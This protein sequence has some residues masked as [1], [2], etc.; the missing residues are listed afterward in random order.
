MPIAEKKMTQEKVADYYGKVLKTKD[1]LKTTACCSIE[2]MPAYMQEPLKL[3]DDEIQQKF[4]GCG[5]PFPLVLD[6]MKI[7]DLGCGTGRDC[8]ILSYLV[9]ESGEVTGVDMTEE[10]LEVANRHLPV[11]MKKF[12]FKKPN[13]RFYKGYIEDLSTIGLPD[14]YFDIVISNCVVNLSPDKESVLREVH[15]VL[16]KGGEFFFSD[17]Y[18]DRRLPEWA[19]HDVVL[20]GECLG[21]ALYWK[22]FERLA[23]KTGFIDPRVVSST[24]INLHDK[25]VIDK[26]G[27]AQ[28]CSVTYR[29]FKLP[30][31]EDACEDYGQTAVYKGTIGAS[32]HQFQ[33]DDHHVFVKGK[34]LPVCSNTAFMLSETRFHPHFE[35]RG[36]LAAHFGLFA[37]CGE[38]PLIKADGGAGTSSPGG[39]C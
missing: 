27:F 18:A 8:Y 30:E 11:Q 7:L 32:P 36:D 34:P 37:G 6:G 2:T 29:L 31:L 21:G 33:L 4:Y 12:G 16:K 1:D 13:V 25:E 26:I 20:L 28:F 22:D 23:R 5:A 35:I 10:Q 24:R 9:G 19:R 15:R 17:V 3:I 14:G 38:T 39:C